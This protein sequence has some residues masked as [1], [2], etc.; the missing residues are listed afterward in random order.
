MTEQISYTKIKSHRN[1][2]D[3]PIIDIALGQR[4]DYRQ[5]FAPMYNVVQWLVN[6]FTIQDLEGA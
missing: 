4:I 6:K 5:A 3:L 2:K 1:C